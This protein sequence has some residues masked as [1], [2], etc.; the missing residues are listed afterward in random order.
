MDAALAGDFV[1]IETLFPPDI[2]PE[3]V[4]KKDE[5]GRT[6][7]HWA[8]TTMSR[9]G[10]RHADC[11]KLLIERKA[12]VRTKDDGGWTP[13]LSACACGNANTVSVLIAANADISNVEEGGGNGP[14]HLASSK[15]HVDV[16]KL[17]LQAG[18]DPLEPDYLGQ[19]ALHKA[20]GAG[21]HQVVS[22][23]LTQANKLLNMSDKEGSTALHLGF[24]EQHLEVVR[25]LLEAGA[26]SK[27]TNGSGQTPP[28]LAPDAFCEAVLNA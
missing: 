2:E 3:R 13:L 11:V 1:K 24:Y 10:Q 4:N 5:D 18:C 27:V 17:L 15:G 8:S 6:A 20:A 9:P 22:V 7:L 19:T 14:L 23:L 21:R 16:V 12:N 25:V 26:S 28:D